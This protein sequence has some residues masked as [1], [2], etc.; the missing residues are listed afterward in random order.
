MKSSLV[1]GLGLILFALGLFV[2]SR[3][4]VWGEQTVN[5]YAV[6]SDGSGLAPGGLVTSRLVYHYEYEGEPLLA[7]GMILAGIG[8]LGLVRSPTRGL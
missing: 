1:F 2:N 5:H 4:A 3:T 6:A 7:L 8:A